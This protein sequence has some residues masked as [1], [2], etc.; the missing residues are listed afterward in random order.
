MGKQTTRRWA[1]T[2]ETY[3]T[4][5]ANYCWISQKTTT[6]LFWNT[7]FLP[8]P[9]K[10]RFLYLPKHQPQQGVSKSRLS[11]DKQA[12]RQL[13]RCVNVRRS[14][15]KAPELDHK[16]VY[17]KVRIP[18]RSAL[19]RRMRES[20]KEFPRMAH[21]KWLMTDPNL[22]CQVANAM[23]A[24]L[25]IPDGTCINHIA[26]DMDDVM[27]SIA[28]AELAPRSK[29]PRRAQGWCA[30][31]DVEAEINEAWQ[32]REEARRRLRT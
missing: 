1:Y 24:A 23:R 12:V 7:F 15:L 5:T 6:S 26:I 13:A 18:R 8:P 28:A 10:W 14:P 30:G 32:Q 3:S 19:N 20:T 27:L 17:A 4:K 9:K 21:L 25:P 2:A 29:H 31:P 11:P 22:R 16:L